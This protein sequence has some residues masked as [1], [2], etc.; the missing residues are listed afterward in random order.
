MTAKVPRPPFERA[1]LVGAGAGSRGL[2][3]ALAARAAAHTEWIPERDEEPVPHV[4][5]VARQEAL[6]PHAGAP[7]PIDLLV[8]VPAK[9][10]TVETLLWVGRHPG[11]LVIVVADSLA[12]AY[13]SAAAATGLASECFA[14][15]AHPL[16]T[17]RLAAEERPDE[18]FVGRPVAI[19]AAPKAPEAAIAGAERFWILL[20]AIPVIA[21]PE[22]LDDRAA[23]TEWL[24]DWSAAALARVAAAGVARGSSEELLT[25]PAFLEATALLT[26]EPEISVAAAARRARRIV[27][28][29]RALAGELEQAA[30]LLEAGNVSALEEWLAPAQAFRRRFPDV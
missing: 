11:A 26:R 1:R 13:A 9:S 25:G 16:M 29:M 14:S 30:A 19:A 2:A 22:A 20:G 18:A 21:E 7:A 27:P 17:P 4:T 6:A 28:A 24:P 8:L 3:H 12:E 23:I 15:A 10:N 5:L